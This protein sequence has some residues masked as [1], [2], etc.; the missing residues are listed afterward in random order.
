MAYK[1]E[2]KNI[3]VEDHTALLIFCVNASNP[4]TML[5][6][7]GVATNKH[8]GELYNITRTMMI[9]LEDYLLQSVTTRALGGSLEMVAFCKKA[10]PI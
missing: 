1:S 5:A 6:F 3:S 8:G 4:L 7:G 2:R 9:A 10:V